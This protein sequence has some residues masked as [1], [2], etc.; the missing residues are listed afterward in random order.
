MVKEEDTIEFCALM[1]L[2]H[3]YTWNF[4]H[5]KF[6]VSEFPW[7]RAFFDDI[8]VRHCV[9]KEANEDLRTISNEVDEPLGV[10]YTIKDL[11]KLNAFEKLASRLK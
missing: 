11:K 1:N 6:G 3:F 5:E 10:S 8:N 4:F 2:A 9:C 7:A